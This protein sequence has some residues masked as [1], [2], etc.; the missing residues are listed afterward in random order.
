MIPT[1][2]RRRMKKRTM[3]M[4]TRTWRNMI[5]PVGERKAMSKLKRKKLKIS[6]QHQYHTIKE[7][8]RKRVLR[9]SAVKLNPVLRA[10]D[11]LL[12]ALGPLLRVLALGQ[13][14]AA[15]EDAVIVAADV[16]QGPQVDH[17]VAVLGPGILDH[18][19]ATEDGGNFNLNASTV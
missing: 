4:K 1:M 3:M 5:S 12:P 7:I 18:V 13:G 15:R 11:P 2:V 14:I 6:L 17:H 8:T 9:E 16:D 19:H 10:P